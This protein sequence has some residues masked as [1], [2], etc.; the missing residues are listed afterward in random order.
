M[1]NICDLEPDIITKLVY[2]HTM[3]T[4]IL[5]FANEGEKTVPQSVSLF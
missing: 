3:Q 5:D 4:D 1:L 2:C